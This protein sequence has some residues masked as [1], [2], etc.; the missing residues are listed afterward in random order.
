V[1]LSGHDREARR[2]VLRDRQAAVKPLCS[3]ING[4]LTA[5]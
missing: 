1:H 5:A 2:D 4:M 3:G